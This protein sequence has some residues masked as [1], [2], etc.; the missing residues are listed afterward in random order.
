MNNNTTYLSIKDQIATV[1]LNNPSRKNVIDQN[2]AGNLNAIF[3]QLN[4][5]EHIS[6]VVITSTA[7]VF[8]TG[9]TS[10]NAKTSLS[11]RKQLLHELSIS[12]NLT[13]LKV[14][15]IASINGD[16][17]EHGLEIALCADIRICNMSARFRFNDLHNDLD[18]PMDG[19]TQRLPRLIG[20]SWAMDMLLTGRIVSAQEALSIGLVNK[21]VKDE[22]LEK[23]TEQVASSIATGGTI[24]N[25]YVKESVYKGMEMSL[26]EGLTLETD[27]NV[28]LQSTYDRSEGIKSFLEKRPPLFR[29]E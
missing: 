28:I 25:Q 23:T 15:L 2:M 27:L 3:H 5:N 17:M 19:G 24:A 10:I 16:A 18:F 12:N 11:E 14:P 13:R 26:I 20:S 7:P 21:V 1:V 6:V 29:G 9:R 22:L 4:E 8:S